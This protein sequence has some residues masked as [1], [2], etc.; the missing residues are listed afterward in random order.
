MFYY[1]VKKKNIE[2]IIAEKIRESAM[3]FKLDPISVKK[4]IEK[5]KASMLP[6]KNKQSYECGKLK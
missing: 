6:D 3:K 2:K 5:I 1:P 4:N